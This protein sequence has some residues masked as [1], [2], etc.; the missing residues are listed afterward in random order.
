MKLTSIASLILLVVFI[1]AGSIP[2]DGLVLW[3]PFNGNTS[4]SVGTNDVYTGSVLYYTQSWDGHPTNAACFNHGMV[5]YD[6][7]G[8]PLKNDAR[9]A[10]V[11]VK[12]YSYMGDDTTRAGIFRWGGET[13]RQN[14]DDANNFGIHFHKENVI[15]A[16]PHIYITGF[17]QTIE[18]P[19]TVAPKTQYT[20]LAVTYGYGT[21]KFYVNGELYS[22]Y[23]VTGLN[24]TIP[25]L[26]VGGNSNFDALYSVMDEFLIYNR[27]LSADEITH[28]Y[29]GNDH[30]TNNKPSF[31][32]TPIPM[33]QVGQQYS[34]TVLTEDLDG[35][36][37]TLSLETFPTDMTLNNNVVSWTPSISD[38][39]LNDVVIVATDEKGDSTH[40]TFD[41]SVTSGTGNNS[42]AILTNPVTS[43]SIDATQYLYD[44]NASDVDGDNLTYT[45]TVKPSGMDI[46]EN[47]GLIFWPSTF[48]TEENH[49]VTVIV[50]DGNGGSDEQS[51]ILTVTGA[52]SNSAPEFVST[53]DTLA[54][55]GTPYEY[56]IVTTDADG[57]NVTLTLN[58]APTGMSLNGNVLNWIPMS[59]AIGTHSIIL[60]ARDPNGGMTTQTFNLVVEP[61]VSANNQI[62]KAQ[63]AINKKAK[64]YFNLMGRKVTG[65]K[66]IYVRNNFKK[67][68]I[69]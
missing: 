52:Q 34:Y 41:I 61:K 32:S 64:V 20:H 37:V 67:V 21:L 62:K 30:L 51:F 39:G 4:D 1:A 29:T 14:S 59:V 19:G 31:T 45:L 24:S 42:P 69:K 68:I 54:Q 9:S 10:A 44:V 28:I 6:I 8:I 26:L 55:T 65:T 57:D 66:G 40:Q 16:E 43:V 56:T 27:E 7:V 5:T 2:M 23:T 33:I 12:P 63:M 11:W 25:D 36:S 38:L 3:Y 15:G 46:T 53:P 58:T 49:N 17:D 47:D 60:V 13:A 35:D 48:M 50:V 18:I 22:T